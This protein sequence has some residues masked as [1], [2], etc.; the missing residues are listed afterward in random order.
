M[1]VILKS[2]LNF[3][4]AS[5]NSD[6]GD[7]GKTWFSELSQYITKITKPSVQYYQAEIACFKR[8]RGNVWWRIHDYNPKMSR[9]NGEA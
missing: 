8:K 6:R 4:M 2:H 9:H 1:D 5:N 7:K 3:L